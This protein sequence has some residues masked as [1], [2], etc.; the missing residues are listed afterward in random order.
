MNLLDY[1]RT[2]A[3]GDY[4][5]MARLF[6]LFLCAWII[7]EGALDMAADTVERVREVRK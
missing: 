5:D 4:I 1:I 7:V 2:L 6:G 3:T